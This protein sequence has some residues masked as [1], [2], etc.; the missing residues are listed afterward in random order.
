[1]ANAVR[2]EITRFVDDHQPGW[3]ECRLID[4]R[5]AVW[6]FIEKVP[7]VTVAWLDADSVYPQQGEIACEIISGALNSQPDDIL[8]IDTGSPWHVEA[9][10]GDTRFEVFAHQMVD[11]NWGR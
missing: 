1:V 5:E 7:V 2:V 4:A 6:L 11:E 3:V 10:T 9:T 8:L